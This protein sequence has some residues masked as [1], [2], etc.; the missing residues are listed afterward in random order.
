MSQQQDPQEFGIG[1]VPADVD[2]TTEA[3]AQIEAAEIASRQQAPTSQ[4]QRRVSR[5]SYRG[6]TQPGTMMASLGPACPDH[7]DDMSG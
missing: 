3:L 2:P 7:Y 6:C 1:R 4:A 5:C